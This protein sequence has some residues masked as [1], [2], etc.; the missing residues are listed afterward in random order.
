[1]KIVQIAVEPETDYAWGWLYALTDTG[2]VFRIRLSRIRLSGEKEK[3]QEEPLPE[4]PD[5]TECVDGGL[6]YGG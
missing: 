6:S 1:M 2:R 3:W 4:L 5:I